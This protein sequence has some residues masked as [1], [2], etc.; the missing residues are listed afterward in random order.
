MSA[1]SLPLVSVIIPT[2]NRVELLCRAVGSVLGQTYRNLECI[3]VDDCSTDDTAA[4]LQEIGEYD[5]RLRLLRHDRN[6]R[7]SA[8]RNTG[9]RSAQGPLIAFLDDDD[10]WLPK[11]LEKQVDLL[12]TVP[13]SVGL[14]YCWMDYLRGAESVDTRRPVLR[15]RIFEQV[16]VSQPLGNC[17]TL[18]VRREAV[19]RVG[20]F[21][22]GL[23]RG[24]DGDF[25][26]RVAQHYDVDVL[27][28]VLVHCHVEHDGHPRITST[29]RE[30]RLE[31]A[32]GHEAKLVKFNS[33]L[34]ARSDLRAALLAKIGREYAAAGDLRRAC[35]HLAA[36]WWARPSDP[37]ILKEAARTLIA[38][39]RAV[40]I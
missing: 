24:N 1:L 27:P 39:A 25:I 11:K 29:S 9:L 5:G 18:L 12:M 13:D 7:A 33:I 34:Q 20:G 21:D 37:R 6:R 17:S 4:R 30:G 23:P 14:I 19:N 2:H 3:V 36:A 15:G 10:V 16:L 32:R 28:E 40:R 26:R 31:S 8:A 35:S 38:Y 22:E